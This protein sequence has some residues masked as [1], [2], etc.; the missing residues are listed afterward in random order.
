MSEDPVRREYLALSRRMTD[1]RRIKKALQRRFHPDKNGDADSVSLFQRIDDVCHGAF[2]GRTDEAETATVLREADEVTRL[3]RAQ[4]AR[5]AAPPPPPP[6]PVTPPPPPVTPPPPPVTPP[7]PPPMSPVT[8]PPPPPMS[9]VT[10]PPPPPV[11]PPPP[12]PQLYVYVVHPFPGFEGRR[13][14]IAV[15]DATNDLR[16]LS[17][18]KVRHLRIVANAPASFL[19]RPYTSLNSLVLCVLATVRPNRKSKTADKKDYVCLNEVGPA[20]RLKRVGD[21]LREYL[22]EPWRS[23]PNAPAG[24]APV[25]AAERGRSC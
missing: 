5:H 13:A 7:P 20:L 3:C 8:P 15:Y 22:E 19:E 6:P 9:P 14:K 2:G 16:E 12:P 24:D 1:P 10:P 25:D 4:L 11:T 21:V 17:A 23:L 18:Q